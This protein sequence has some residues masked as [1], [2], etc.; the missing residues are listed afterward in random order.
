MCAYMLDIVDAFPDDAVLGVT[1]PPAPAPTSFNSFH[2]Y[3]PRTPVSAAADQKHSLAAEKDMDSKCESIP[4]KGNQTSSQ[5][6][7]QS[8][9]LPSGM[10]PYLVP[11]ERTSAAWDELDAAFQKRS[12]QKKLATVLSTTDCQEN[13]VTEYLKLCQQLTKSITEKYSDLSSEIIDEYLLQQI[14]AK[15][16]PDVDTQKENKPD[17]VLK[18]NE[19]VEVVSKDILLEDSPEPGYDRVEYCYRAGK[20]Y[21]ECY[22]VNGKVVEERAVQFKC[23]DELLSSATLEKINSCTGYSL[24]PT[25]SK[26]LSPSMMP[27]AYFSHS[28][29]VYVQAQLCH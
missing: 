22:S 26:E 24:T 8:F 16:K 15:I 3:L 25:A 29:H 14:S 28:P 19:H 23:A 20:G 1:Q 7:A 9:R 5:D 4:S 6:E 11:Q 13:R 2:S 17:L 18:G 21:V 12:F 27:T 10:H